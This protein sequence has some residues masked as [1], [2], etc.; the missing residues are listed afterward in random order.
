MQRRAGKVSPGAA[1]RG[2]GAGG[3]AEE[4]RAT[5]RRSPRGARAGAPRNFLVWASGA[6][7]SVSVVTPP[8]TGRRKGG[9]KELEEGREGSAASGTECRAMRARDA[10]PRA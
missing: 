9:R 7:V 10:A 6:E 2:F 4:G 3:R 5:R 8:R 1:G